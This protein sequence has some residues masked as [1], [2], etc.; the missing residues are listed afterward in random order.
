MVTIGSIGNR[1]VIRIR[2]RPLAG[3]RS[4]ATIRREEQQL[5]HLHTPAV[6]HSHRTRTARLI[7]PARDVICRHAIHVEWVAHRAHDGWPAVEP[8]HI[9]AAAHKLINQ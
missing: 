6:V 2:I 1:S 3:N 7:H 5:E 9:I 8:P 4:P